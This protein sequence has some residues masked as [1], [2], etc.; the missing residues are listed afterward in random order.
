MSFIKRIF[1]SKRDESATE[2]KSIDENLL[3]IKLLKERLI[4]MGLQVD[5]N[6]GRA[7]I[8]KINTSIRARVNGKTQHP[9]AVVL[10]LDFHI[11][12]IDLFD[13][14]IYESLAGI[15][16]GNNIEAAIKNGV[17]SFINGVFEA[18]KDSFADTHN[19]KLD[20]QTEC[21]GNVLL[22]HP[23]IGPVQV[24]GHFDMATVDEERIFNLLKDEIKGKLKSKR[25]YWI[26][27]YVARQADGGMICQCL[28]NNKPFPEAD[29]IMENYVKVWNTENK[30][31]GEKQYIIIRQCDKTWNEYGIKESNNNKF[32]KECAEHAIKVLEDRNEN[33]NEEALINRIADFTKNTNLAWELYCFIPSIYC[34]I[35]FR[36]ADY[37]DMV[38]II[39]PDGRKIN[40][41]LNGFKSYTA[42]QEA[43]IESLQSDKDEK[44]IKNVLFLSADVKVLNSAVMGG[45][46]M[47]DL[48]FTPLQLFAPEGYVIEGSGI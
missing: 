48:Q 11:I 44:K 14:G 4:A 40:L 25:F 2:N 34:R 35:I 16:E 9:N 22:W 10:Q 38:T 32:I 18:Y 17:D 45:S 26:K 29:R 23:K 30:F 41:E 36:E 5:D 27:I 20:I 28:F 8:P 47:E 31:K 12:N 3:I 33:E 43:V 19:P 7:N 21:N 42:A 1:G 39:M 37:S 15:A 46:K 13:E 6:E 24:Q